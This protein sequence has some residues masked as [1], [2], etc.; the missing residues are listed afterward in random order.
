M[1]QKSNESTPQRPGGDR[2][3]DDIMVPIDL[4]FFI[5]QLRTESTW[6]ES[7]RNAITVFKTD[8][9]RIVLIGLH[10]G[11]EMARHVAD[12]IISVHVLEGTIDF[13]TDQQSVNLQKNNIVTLHKNVPHS[14][15]AEEEAIFLL[16]LTTTSK[17]EK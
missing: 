13:I 5:N 2:L 9:L 8:G 7:N 14:V 11:A 16:T 10:K 17:P 3:V 6:K 12:G 15:K 1:E 4:P